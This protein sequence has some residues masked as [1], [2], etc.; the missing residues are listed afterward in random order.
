MFSLKLKIM[1][2]IAFQFRDG[3]AKKCGKN[4]KKY[5]VKGKPFSKSCITAI[6]GLRKPKA[7]QIRN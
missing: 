1:S 6:E 4:K 2:C 5:H 7:T 3:L